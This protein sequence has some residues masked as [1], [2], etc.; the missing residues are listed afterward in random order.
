MAVIRQHSDENTN[1]GTLQEAYTEIYPVM[2]LNFL[3][4]I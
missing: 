1:Q 2:L 3:I 4:Y